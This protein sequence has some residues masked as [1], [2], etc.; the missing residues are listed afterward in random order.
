[1]TT[2]DEALA[3]A[4]IADITTTGR[5]TGRP[6]R[7]ETAFHCLDGELYLTGK[8]GFPR[9]WMANLRANPEFTLHLKRGVEADLAAKATEI[10]DPIER[11]DVLYRILTQSWGNPEDKANAILPR[12]VDGSPLVRFTV[13]R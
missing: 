1:M 5:R 3:A 10:T 12:W 2:V 7:I 9:D 11:A 6:H 8:P 4:G 13:E